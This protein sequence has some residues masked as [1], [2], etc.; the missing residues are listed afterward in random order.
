MRM[1]AAVRD[2]LETKMSEMV[3]RSGKATE[4]RFVMLGDKV[5]IKLAKFDKENKQLH[6]FNIFYGGIQG[7]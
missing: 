5:K 4:I 6:S 3:S 1:P 7:T 2:Q